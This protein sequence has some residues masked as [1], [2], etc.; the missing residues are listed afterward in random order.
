MKKLTIVAF[1]CNAGTRRKSWVD[2][3]GAPVNQHSEL[4]Q[5]AQPIQWAQPI[6]TAD[7]V[8]SANQHSRLSEL[9]QWET[10]TPNK[11]GW[12]PRNSSQG[13]LL[14]SPYT[15]IYSPHT[16][17]RPYAY[18]YI[19][20]KKKKKTGCWKIL[21]E[22]QSI[23]SSPFDLPFLESTYNLWSIPLRWAKSDLHRVVNKLW[24]CR[25]SSSP[26]N[27]LVIPQTDPNYHSK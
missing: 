10:L 19:H 7:S 26:W 25:S 20:R 2:S 22:L 16:Y 17:E 13:C 11:G 24:R 4:S 21:N 12:R 9:S 15:H 8:S 5:S 18:T 14:A 1:A 27:N 23:N 6:S 3:W